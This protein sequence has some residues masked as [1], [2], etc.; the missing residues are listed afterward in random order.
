MQVLLL[1]IRTKKKGASLT[2]IDQDKEERCNYKT[3]TPNRNK[4][5]RVEFAVS[6]YLV[7]GPEWV[8]LRLAV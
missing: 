5:N 7:D 3:K 6:S 8:T 1:L 2:S 4:D